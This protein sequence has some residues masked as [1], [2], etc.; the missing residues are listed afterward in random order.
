MLQDTRE[1]E[2][3][4]DVK[5][6]ISN[7]LAGFVPGYFKQD[8]NQLPFVIRKYVLPVTNSLEIDKKIDH[9]EVFVRDNLQQKQTELNQVWKDVKKNPQFQ[10][11]FAILFHCVNKLPF[12]KSISN[13]LRKVL[14]KVS[15]FIRMYL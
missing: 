13:E 10:R 9:L 6:V 1:K 2:N 5:P 11:S 12:T 4:I 15:W 8:S 3:D 14:D 7:Y